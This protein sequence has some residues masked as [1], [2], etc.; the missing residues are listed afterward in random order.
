[1]RSCFVD[2]GEA[3]VAEPPA[4]EELG[5]FEGLFHAGEFLDEGVGAELVGAF[6]VGGL[7]GGAEDDDD[8]APEVRMLADPGEDFQTVDFGEFEVEEDQ[9][10]ER[11]LVAVGIG[12][13]AGEIIQG[14]IWP[15]VTAWRGLMMAAFL[16]TC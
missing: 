14:A 8:E 6:D 7:G 2:G 9:A 11:V 16:N 10:R 12:A 4:F 13:G 5:D 3:V 1:M 15:S